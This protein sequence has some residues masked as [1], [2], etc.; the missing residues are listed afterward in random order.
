MSWEHEWQKGYQGVNYGWYHRDWQDP[1][2]RCR[3]TVIAC[4]NDIWRE[5]YLIKINQLDQNQVGRELF[6]T[7]FDKVLTKTVIEEIDQMGPMVFIME[8][9]L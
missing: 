5:P 9:K 4:K 6:T 8:S 7:K 2:Q 1:D 3:V